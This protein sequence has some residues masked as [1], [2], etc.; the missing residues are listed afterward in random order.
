MQCN[1][2]NNFEIHGLLY[3]PVCRQWSILRNGHLVK[4][5]SEG[6][7]CRILS[8]WQTA[9]GWTQTGIE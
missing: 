7:Q 2:A 1:D 8:R 4:G 3:L 9:L 5:N 6:E